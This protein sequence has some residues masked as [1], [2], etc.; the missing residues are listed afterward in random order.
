MKKLLLGSVAFAALITGPAMAAD[1]GV[2]PV[3]KSPIAVAAYS[4]DGFYAGFSAG[5][6]WTDPHSREIHN[7]VD[8]LAI[9]GVG[10]LPI[11]YTYS[12]SLSANDKHNA[13]AVFTFTTGYNMVFGSWVLGYQS[14]VS[15]NKN[16][17]RLEGGGASRANFA[18]GGVAVTSSRAGDVFANV[19]NDWTI[20]QMARIGFL[21]SPSTQVYGLVGWSWGG[22]TFD[23]Y[24]TGRTGLDT[25][26]LLA[27]IIG[28]PHAPTG[29]ND[30]ISY[31]LNG[32]TWGAGIE[33]NYGWLRAFVQYKGIQY[34]DRDVATPANTTGAL[35]VTAGGTA[36]ITDSVVGTALRSLGADQHQITAG[37]IIPLDRAPW[38]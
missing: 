18:V 37:F 10:A 7:T 38:R 27:G 1:L 20:S 34:R 11:A 3:Y 8:T 21:V 15:L 12:D 19:S 24:S 30:V 14:E 26:S 36:T 25:I 22:Y 23:G 33:Q 6:T 9:T 32:F 13:G 5:G 35:T 17:L 4:W 16:N 31:T 2:R 29:R 28:V